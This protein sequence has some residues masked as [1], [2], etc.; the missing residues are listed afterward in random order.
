MSSRRIA[1]SVLAALSVS[2][3][4]ATGAQAAQADSPAANY[5]RPVPETVAPTPS[6]FT[7]SAPDH[8]AAGSG[9]SDTTDTAAHSS[10][11]TPKAV[12]GAGRSPGNSPIT[13]ELALVVGSFTLLLAV[14]AAGVAVHRMRSP[15][16]GRSA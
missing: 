4:G 7:K 3:S 1:A 9:G 8:S 2:L 16:L 11:D 5:P 13:F 10:G 6:D 14:G 12:V 15:R